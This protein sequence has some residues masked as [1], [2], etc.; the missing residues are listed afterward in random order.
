MDGIVDLRGLDLNDSSDDGFFFMADLLILCVR[1]IDLESVFGKRESRRRS[2]QNGAV[3]FIDSVCLV[4]L[5]N[6]VC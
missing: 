6:L 1:V 4:L 2:S 5:L 3:E